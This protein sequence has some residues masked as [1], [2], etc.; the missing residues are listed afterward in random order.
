M[1]PRQPNEQL[2]RDAVVL[3]LVTL[4][5]VFLP[6]GRDDLPIGA[7]FAVTEADRQEGQERDRPAMVSV[8]EHPITT[9]EQATSIRRADAAAAGRDSTTEFVPF[10]LNV[11]QVIDCG[12]VDR[13]RVL[14]DPRPPTDGPGA[15]GHSGIEGLDRRPGEARL[16]VKEMLDKIAVA[17][18]RT[19]PAR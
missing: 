14:A 15:E 19:P 2:P 1:A 17:A 7:A 4:K 6:H 10:W 13:L 16:I 11:A 5:D 12:P 3:R 9:V 18:T 8:W